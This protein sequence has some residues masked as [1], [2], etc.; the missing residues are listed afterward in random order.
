MQDKK[1][2]LIP[3]G[4]YHIYNRA[5]GNERLYFSD[6][7]YHYFLEKY[8][9]YI[10]HIA[11]T[12]CFCLMPNHFHFLVRIK[13]EESLNETFKVSE[14]LEGLLSKQ[15][16]NFF[17]GYAKAFNKQQGRKGSLFMHTF[18][19][20]RITDERYLRKLVHYIH[21]NPKEAGLVKKIEEWKFSSYN[22]IAGLTLTG[23]ETLS[24]L[25]LKKE[26]VLDWFED[27]ENFIYCHKLQPT[28]TGIEDF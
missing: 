27:K 17:N 13:S 20:K 15:F 14:N 3:D 16:S 12:F 1:A 23:F 22:S 18:K 9:Q 7:N 4:A 19:R 8:N 24:E 25:E 26:E 28:E 5:N 6:Q 11:D 10:S 21:F 2:I